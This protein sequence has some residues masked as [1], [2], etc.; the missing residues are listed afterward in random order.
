[1]RAFALIVV[2]TIALLG[3]VSLNFFRKTLVDA[4]E[5]NT[6]QFAAQ[7]SRIVDN[8]ITY[9]NDIAL[10]VME[11]EDVRA[12]MG[13]PASSSPR[14]RSRIGQFLGS[15]RKVRK[16]IDGVFLLPAGR[17]AKVLPAYVIASSP[18]A[19]VNPDYDFGRYPPP[20]AFARGSVGG[21][22]S[23]SVSSAHVRT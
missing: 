23:P 11:D 6:M 17:G 22:D 20:G 1:M 7:L 10:V 12:Y 3:T 8:Y 4:S 18:G 13:A 14:N 19:E 16:D 2:M 21:I 15:V 9:M 5:Q